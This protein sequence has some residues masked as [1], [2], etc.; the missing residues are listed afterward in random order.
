MNRDRCKEL[1]PVFEAFISGDDLEFRL[2]GK[3]G[4]MMFP[5]DEELAISFPAVDYEYRI[6]PKPREFWIEDP[7][8]HDG[9]PLHWYTPEGMPVNA[10]KNGGY[11]KFREV[12]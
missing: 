2:M 3:T 9:M 8:L 11:I 10:I 5:K 6:K 1:M 12:L 7:N 4:W